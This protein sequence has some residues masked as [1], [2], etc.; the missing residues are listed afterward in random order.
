M[1]N[2]SKTRM[3][4]PQVYVPAVKVV[5]LDGSI[6]V[7]AGKPVVVEELIGTGEAARILGISQRWVETQCSEGRFTTAHKPGQQPNSRWRLARS[8]VVARKEM[9]PK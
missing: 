1:I 3:A 8:E 2:S 4:V 7:K 6:L 9:E 5:Q